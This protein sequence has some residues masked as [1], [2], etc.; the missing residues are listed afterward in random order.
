VRKRYHSVKGFV[1]G[2]RAFIEGTHASG[3]LR[4]FPDDVDN[5]F[6]EAYR[7]DQANGVPWQRVAES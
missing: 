5:Y 6:T 2:E 3:Q 7:A 4:T 1:Y